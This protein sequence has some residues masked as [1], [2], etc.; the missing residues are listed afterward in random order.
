MVTLPSVC[1]ANDLAQSF[2]YACHIRFAV[3]TPFVQAL[4]NRLIRF[5]LQIAKA[6]VFQFPLDL[7]DTKPVCQRRKNI[8]R[9]LSLLALFSAGI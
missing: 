3:S 1:P 6:Q 9:F 4:G 7:P 2:D 5:W 8:K